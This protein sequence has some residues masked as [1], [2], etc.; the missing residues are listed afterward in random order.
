MGIRDCPA[1]VSGNESRQSSTGLPKAWEATAG[2]RF[3]TKHA[4]ESE[5]LPIA[6]WSEAAWDGPARCPR[7]RAPR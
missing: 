7:A 6:F 1:A 4:R 5:D 3:A 2:R